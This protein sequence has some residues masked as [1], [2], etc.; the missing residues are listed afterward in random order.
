MEGEELSDD[1][2]AGDEQGSVSSSSELVREE[3]ERPPVAAIFSRLTASR[4]TAASGSRGAAG[5]LEETG[6]AAV[7]TDSHY[8]ALENCVRQCVELYEEELALEQE[9]SLQ[10]Q[11]EQA[12]SSSREKSSLFS[13]RQN[14]NPCEHPSEVLQLPGGNL[15]PVRSV[16]AS[17]LVYAATF[18][19]LGAL[20]AATLKHA[21]KCAR[22]ATNETEA[23]RIWSSETKRLW[24][25]SARDLG[26][27]LHWRLALL[28]QVNASAVLSLPL[29][30]V[31][32]AAKA[33]REALCFASSRLVLA[34]PAPP[35]AGDE[36]ALLR[37]DSLSREDCDEVFGPLCASAGRPAESALR[38]GFQESLAFRL[39][40][41]ARLG[42][43][44]AWGVGSCPPS[45][46]CESTAL[47]ALVGSWRGALLPSLKNFAFAA[48]TLWQ[49]RQG[50]RVA[51]GL[52]VS[53]CEV[54]RR[55]PSAAAALASGSASC[56]SQL[57]LEDKWASLASVLLM[58]GAAPLP[59]R[60]GQHSQP[61]PAVGGLS[62]SLTRA[63]QTEG[64]SS[65]TLPD[66]SDQ[67]GGQ[68]TTRLESGEDKALPATDRLEASLLVQLAESLRRAPPPALLARQR[69][70][71]VQLRGE[72][73]QDL[74][75][76]YAEVLSSVC[77]EV[78][79]LG[80]T[81]LCANG[82]TEAGEE[83]E[84]TVFSPRLRALLSPDGQGEDEAHAEAE[85]ESL[86]VQGVSV[87]QNPFDGGS[88]RRGGEGGGA[89]LK[90]SLL[91][92]GWT[93]SCA[94]AGWEPT[95][96]PRRSSSLRDEGQSAKSE[97]P[98][99]ERL[100]AL[101]RAQGEAYLRLCG[102]ASGRA[103]E[104][105]LLGDACADSAAKVALGGGLSPEAQRVVGVLYSVGLLMA[106]AVVT[107]S[108]I[109]LSLAP[110][111]WELL[112]GRFPS[113]S[114]LFTQDVLAARQLR[115]LR[116]PIQTLSQKTLEARAQGEAEPSPEEAAD[117]AGEA[118]RVQGG[119]DA[120][121][122]TREAVLRLLHRGLCVSDSLG[123]ECAL[124]PGGSSPEEETRPTS[125]AT[126]PAG[127]L[128]RMLEFEMDTRVSECWL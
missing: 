42:R 56:S 71:A 98:S 79:R 92:D 50:R 88:W 96:I 99:L 33:S 128:E 59:P 8:E 114:L 27:A 104:N 21:E 18:E 58:R 117:L 127:S 100:V 4:A 82:R 10:Q 76:P 37:G 24:P 116:V 23:S 112:L 1:E 78:A 13:P 34:P 86:G 89:L 57:V 109:N 17:A 46:S 122:E 20:F 65:P 90:Q 119:E 68:R 43:G 103:F 35:S 83:R 26:T 61:C 111:V 54:L 29:I 55:P 52:D 72:G 67:D 81:V 84:A 14:E 87:L 77:D 118:A 74:G 2:G 69:S 63:I 64:A 15:R 28:H 44:A 5:I 40:R 32:A 30:E 123:E 48:S 51:G 9:P 126:L 53:P 36:K 101:F 120:F 75:G 115:S 95:G 110:S 3:A 49:A 47:E 11:Q 31:A 38:W 80:L 39:A 106:S 22:D 113:L 121:E 70:F 73:A 60:R 12:S 19:V 105:S 108:P 62:L 93:R 94:G 97:A 41:K 91:L 45:L 107:L 85:A 102:E 16:R 125:P 25:P 7:F 124:L 66:A 6:P